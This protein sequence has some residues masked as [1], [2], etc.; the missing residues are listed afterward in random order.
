MIYQKDTQVHG[1]DTFRFIIDPKSW[2]IN[3]P[4]NCGYCRQLP[5]NMYGRKKG[6]YCLPD[7]LLDISGCEPSK[8]TKCD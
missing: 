8:I 6:S 2:N 7:G 3:E 1:L 5:R 4:E